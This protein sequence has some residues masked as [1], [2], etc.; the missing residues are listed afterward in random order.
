VGSASGESG[1]PAAGGLSED[2]QFDHQT[3]LPLLGASSIPRPLDAI[4][5][6]RL[7]VIPGPG[8]GLQ[9]AIRLVLERRSEAILDELSGKGSV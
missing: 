7:L 6:Q 9:Y 8:A 5:F 3:A 2:A 4:R 1:D